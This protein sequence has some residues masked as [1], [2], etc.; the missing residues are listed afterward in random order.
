MQESC[1]DASRSFWRQK[2]EEAFQ[3]GRVFM[4]NQLGL[5]AVLGTAGLGAGLMF[6]L[7]PDL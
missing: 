6:L 5:G 7:D 1:Q 4:R 3:P 2:I